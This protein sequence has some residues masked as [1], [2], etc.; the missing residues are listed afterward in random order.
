[1]I[2]C[3]IENTCKT[4]NFGGLASQDTNTG[5]YR[6][7]SCFCGKN[8]MV[9]YVVEFTKVYD[10]YFIYYIALYILI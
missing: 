10:I 2:K 4:Y 1:M 9:E 6:F 3:G 5:V 7:K 8:G